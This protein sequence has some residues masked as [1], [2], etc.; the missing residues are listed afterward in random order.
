MWAA[1]RRSMEDLGNKER[2]GGKPWEAQV[3]RHG[4]GPRHMSWSIFSHFPASN[5][6]T[7]PGPTDVLKTTGSN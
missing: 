4:N 5:K 2:Q 1:H 7:Q 6:L 3:V